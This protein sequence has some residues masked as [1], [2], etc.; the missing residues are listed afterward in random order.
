MCVTKNIKKRVAQLG[1]ATKNIFNYGS[2]S[3]EEIKKFKFEKRSNL[4]KKFKIPYFKNNILAT[5]HPET[6]SKVSSKRQIEIFLKSIENFKNT[7]F[8]ITYNNKDESGD[9][10]RK[11][12]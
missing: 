2:L 10:F 1:E 8:I 7:L 11:K 5:F 6:R 4:I 3:S 12:N 9:Y